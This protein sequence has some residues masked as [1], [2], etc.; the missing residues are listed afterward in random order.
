MKPRLFV[1]FVFLVVKM[2]Y[3]TRADLES[4]FSPDE[5]I[6]RADLDRDGQ[7][8][9]AVLAVALADADAIIDG[10]LA[11][12]YRL[13]LPEVPP[14]LTAIACDLARFH[15]WANAATERVRQGYEDALR[16][17]RDIAA[18]KMALPLSA[19]MPNPA[20]ASPAMA[21]GCSGDVL[22]SAPPPVFGGR[23]PHP[24]EWWP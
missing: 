13:P 23:W 4:R 2:P 21:G 22:V 20:A 14:M 5:L 17:L 8:D 3:A 19:P 9:D 15:Y 16:L 6:D 24:D 18:G 11:A 7:P 10:Y 1:P 12:R